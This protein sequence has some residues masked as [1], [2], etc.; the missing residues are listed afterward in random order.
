MIGN[1]GRNAV[2]KEHQNGRNVLNFSVAFTDQF[3]DAQGQ[4]RERTVWAECALW[5]HPNVGP[6]LTQGLQVYVEGIPWVESYTDKEGR[7]AASLK[8]LVNKLKLLG[9]PKREDAKPDAPSVLYGPQSSDDLP[10]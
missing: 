1:L 9:A 5:G 6:Y 7:P 8:V 4:Q 10:F 2:F 3:K